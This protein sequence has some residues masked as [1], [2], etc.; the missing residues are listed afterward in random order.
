MSND[1][2][3]RELG[4]TFDDVAGS[5]SSN[6]RDRVRSAVTQAPEA[7]GPYWIA[8]VAAC[9]I[10]VLI[11]GVLYVAN[12]PNPPSLVAGGHETPSASP[13][14]E[15]TASP[16]AQPTAVPT[17]SALPPFVCGST[18]WAPSQP[19]STPYTEHISDLR[20]GVHSGYDRLTIT[21]DRMPGQVEFHPQSGT[22]FTLSPSG[23]RATLKGKN[24]ILIVMQGTD[25]HTSYSGPTDIVTGY[26]GLAEVRRVE[27]FEGVVQLGLGVNGA[28]CYRA[29][30]LGSPARLVIDVQTAG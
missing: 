10:A 13:S 3:R 20:T 1:D 22:A 7:R 8:G 23:M 25:M 30:Y 16:S 4:H 14:P 24:G 19:A 5:P 9:V 29:F 18:T 12:R 11:V 28:A 2:F 6:L 26:S 27:D 17:Q 15:A 21:F